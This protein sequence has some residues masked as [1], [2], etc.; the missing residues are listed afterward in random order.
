MSIDQRTRM[1]R[2]V[3][4][5]SADEVFGSLFPEAIE[6]NGE[7]TLRG[8]R[9]KGLADLAIECEGRAVTLRDADGRLQLEEGS[10]HA[11]TVAVIEADGLSDLVQDVRSAMGL[12]MNAKLSLTRGG[13]DSW[14]SWEPALRALLD[15]RP[16]HETGMVEMRDRDGDPLDLSKSFTLDDDRDEI[17]NF[18]EQAGFLHLRGV[19][20][21]EEMAEVGADLDAAL[22]RAKPDDGASWWA[23]DAHGRDHAVRVLWFHEQSDAL[24]TLLHGDR[25]QWISELTGDGHDGRKIGAE[26]LVKPLDI[27]SGLSDLP[28]HKDC[29]QGGHSYMCCGLT[30]GISVTGADA[31]SGALGVVPGSHR[32]NLL[33]SRLD[34]DLDLSPIKLETRT[35]DLTVHC[36]DTLHRAH[37]PRDRPRKVVYTGFGLSPLAGDVVPEVSKAEA[38][39]ARA[40]LTNVRDRIDASEQAGEN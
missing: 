33:T 6:R 18:L 13:I 9:T 2:D 15:G 30:V 1:R 5:L 21:E 10:E 19:F 22:A 35:G 29:G 24:R 20:D 11:D 39:A 4:S 36:S 12:A 37:P 14:V 23:G 28:W 31:R 27:V 40:R 26:G 7:L 38:R 3:R 25:V 16:V 8:K 34:H 17:R 32:A